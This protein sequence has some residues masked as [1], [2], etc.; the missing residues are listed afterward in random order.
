MINKKWPFTEHAIECA[1]NKDSYDAPSQWSVAGISQEA[2]RTSLEAPDN[3]R[4]AKALARWRTARAEKE[5]RRQP[6]AP[7]TRIPTRAHEQ[8]AARLGLTAP[9]LMTALETTHTPRLHAEEECVVVWLA[10]HQ[11][12][13]L[14][15]LEGRAA[16][17]ATCQLA[18]GVCESQ[19]MA[20]L[21]C[22][23]FAHN[24]EVQTEIKNMEDDLRREKDASAGSGAYVPGPPGST[25]GERVAQRVETDP[26]YAARPL[27]ERA[28]M[29]AARTFFQHESWR[30]LASNRDVA[31]LLT[32]G[33]LSAYSA[34]VVQRENELSE[35]KSKLPL[36]RR[37]FQGQ[38]AANSVLS[39]LHKMK[40]EESTTS[41]GGSI[42]TWKSL[43]EALLQCASGQGLADFL[44]DKIIVDLLLGGVVKQ[45]DE[46]DF[47]TLGPGA[48]TSLLCRVAFLLHPARGFYSSFRVKPKDASS[49][50]GLS[51]HSSEHPFSCTKYFEELRCLLRHALLLYSSSRIQRAPC[52]APAKTAM[53]AACSVMKAN[54]GLENEECETMRRRAAALAYNKGLIKQLP[55]GQFLLSLIKGKP[56]RTL[57]SM[58]IIQRCAS[59]ISVTT[60]DVLMGE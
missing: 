52:L 6:D 17:L 37:R 39:S 24:V 58:Q 23:E 16:V 60:M 53:M 21:S 51:L 57:S 22:N 38:G 45:L 12:L 11:A 59:I 35:T 19:L 7:S 4:S 34:V 15:S 46:G 41:V 48:I 54:I 50:L 55:K 30:A 25:Q 28:V 29:R 9:Q 31:S 42:P 14:D 5:R 3:Y 40:W 43:Q 2:M 27:G 47:V 32:H 44:T 36:Q 13:P 8:L 26:Q 1:Y 18:G 49:V 33:D 10:S 20:I 56:E